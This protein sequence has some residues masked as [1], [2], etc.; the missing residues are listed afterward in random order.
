MTSTARI[1]PMPFVRLEVAILTVREGRLQVLLVRRAQAPF[2]RRWALPGGALRI[3]LDAGLEEAAAR[4]ASERLGVAPPHLRQL[5]AVG[6]PK[7]E[8]RA[9]WALSIVYR[10]LVPA[11]QLQMQPGKRVEAIA[12]RDADDAAKDDA[13]AF[14]H[15]S[16]IEQAVAAVRQ[17]IE[18]L[19][20]PAGFLPETFTLTELQA[21]CEQILGRGLN[22]ASFRRRLLDHA[23]VEPVAGEM[24]G[25]ANRPAQVHRLS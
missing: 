5:I 19:E 17:D 22:K 20:L 4:V 9:P 21:I 18:D 1:H 24:R 7:R 2:A 3:D 23:V 15:R 10:A 25:G 14:D 6:G 11:E 8:A 12:W 13:L 16:L